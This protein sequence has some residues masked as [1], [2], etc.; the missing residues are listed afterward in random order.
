MNEMSI[1]ITKLSVKQL[2]TKWHLYFFN[3]IISSFFTAYDILDIKDLFYF[4]LFSIDF[5]IFT[6]IAG[7]LMLNSTS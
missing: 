5:F 1:F 3:T 6:Y 7:N 4:I 2:I